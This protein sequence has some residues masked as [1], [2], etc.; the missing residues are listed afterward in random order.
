MKQGIIECV[1]NFSEG[2]DRDVIAQIVAAIQSVPGVKLLHVDRGPSANRTVVT[3]A[4]IPE[5]VTGGAFRGIQ[6]AAGLIDMRKQKGAHPRIGATDVCPLVP[7]ANISMKQTAIWA[8][9]LG[10]DVGERLGIPIYLY[11]EAATRPERRNLAHIRAGGYENL[12]LKLQ[13]P[14]WKPD[15]GG[16]LFNEQTGATVIGARDFLLAYNI[17]LNTDSVKV[18]REIASEVRH[19]G[20]VTKIKGALRYDAVNKPGLLPFTKAIGWYMEEY[21]VAQVSMNLTCLTKTPMHLAFETVSQCAK[22]RG[23]K[24]TGSEIIGLVPLKSMIDAGR[25]FMKKRTGYEP[26]GGDDKQLIMEAV[27]ALGLNELKAFDPEEKI[28]EYA[29]NK[30]IMS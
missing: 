20:E 23:I 28:L 6:K 8:R 5:A 15:F 7:V 17:N 21:R 14:D 30:P 19:S 11:E 25:Y 4:G 2:R 9:Q 10:K 13:D 12:A 18:A 1:P 29:L 22:R 26:P 24:V 27:D 3:F 16:T